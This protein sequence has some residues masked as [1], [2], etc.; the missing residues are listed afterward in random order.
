MTSAGATVQ[1]LQ[2]NRILGTI[3]ITA[4]RSVVQRQDVCENWG[5]LLKKPS[6]AP[7]SEAGHVGDGVALA[8][9][10]AVRSKTAFDKWQCLRPLRRGTGGGGGLPSFLPLPASSS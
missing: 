1:S 4:N 8:C 7:R 6:G 9:I 5:T 3:T 2:G 10:R